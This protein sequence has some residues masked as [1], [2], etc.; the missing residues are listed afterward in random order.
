MAAVVKS[1]GSFMWLYGFPIA[2]LF[3]VLCPFQ[4]CTGHITTGSILAKETSTWGWSRF[5]T[6]IADHW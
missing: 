3:G 1:M 2:Y 4:H 5:S 6:L